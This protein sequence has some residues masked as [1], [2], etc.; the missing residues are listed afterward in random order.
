MN[1]ILTRIATAFVGIAMAVGVGVAVGNNTNFVKA[2]ANNSI[3]FNDLVTLTGYS[4][5]S[6]L[7]NLTATSSGV[8]F[9]FEAITGSDGQKVQV[10]KATSVSSTAFPGV[11]KGLTVYGCSHGSSKSDGGFTVYGST[12]GSTW[13]SA[14]W[15]KLDMAK[16]HGDQAVDLSSITTYTYIKLTISSNRVLKFNR[17]DVSYS[18]GSGPTTY[19]VT[20]NGTNKTS[21]S[22]PTDSNAYEAN[23]VATVL[24]NTGNLKRTGYTWGGWSL[25]QDGSGTVYGPDTADHKTYTITNQS[26]NFYPVWQ[27]IAIPASGSITITGDDFTN[28]YDSGNTKS[29]QT[30]VEEDGAIVTWESINVM[31]NSG[32]Q[33]KASGGNLYNTVSLGNITSIE[34]SGTTALTVYYGTAAG[35]CT[36]TSVGSGNGFFK[37]IKP[38]F[39]TICVIL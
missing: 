25:N 30:L 19:T 36:S 11:V 26:V 5:G 23:E 6:E 1:K 29:H 14:L 9:T 13:S 4:G 21:G 18:D 32:V 12:N 33:F 34:I 27:K 35:S 7:N 22:V 17:I 15:S 8:T 2:S 20:Y 28:S 16:D 3:S 39:N 31:K 37:I 10:K 38:Y 24:G